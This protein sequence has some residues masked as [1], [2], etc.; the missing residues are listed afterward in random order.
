[1][2]DESGP[3]VSVEWLK[4]AIAANRKDVVILECSYEKNKD[5]YKD[6][7]RGHIPGA[8]FFDMDEC[9]DKKSPYPNMLPPPQVF[10]FYCGQLGLDNKSKI[11]LY[12]NNPRGLFGAARVFWMFKA[13]S[14]NPV[15]ILNGGLAAWKQSDLD[16]TT[17]EVRLPPKIF[18]AILKPDHVKVYED[19]VGFIHCTDMEQAPQII[20][21]RPPFLYHCGRI[22]RQSVNIPVASV[23]SDL[24]NTTMKS[25]E[26]LEKLF[27]DANIDLQRKMVFMCSSG[28]AASVLFFAA[29]LLGVSPPQIAVYDGSWSEWEPRSKGRHGLMEYNHQHLLH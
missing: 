13:F 7:I 29:M 12:D 4:N 6:F 21:A 25:K 28:V 8:I 2:A 14:T 10:A 11:I 9:R 16:L 17:A 1:M 20:D 26:D 19:I 18:H 15:Q 24:P 23:L 27:K 5:M 3:L 22:P